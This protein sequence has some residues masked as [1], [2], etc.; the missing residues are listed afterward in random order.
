MDKKTRW[1]ISASTFGFAFILLI[2][3]IAVFRLIA[4]QELTSPIGLLMEGVNSI[5]VPLDQLNQGQLTIFLIAFATKT[6]AAI[7]ICV[8]LMLA[9]RGFLASDFFIAKNVR[10]FKI[11]SWAALAYIGGQFFEGMGNN[12]VSATQGVDNNTLPNGIDDPGFIPMYILMMVLSM[13]AVALTR[14]VKLQEDQEG[15]I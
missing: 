12:W 8:T 1:D 3:V 4:W 5:H 15:L 10:Y 9:T 11:A 6:I 2:T 14:A 13:M 7:T